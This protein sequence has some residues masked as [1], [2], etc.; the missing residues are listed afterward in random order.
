LQLEKQRHFAFLYFK[1]CQM[2]VQVLPLQR[3]S[4][5]F[6]IEDS[7]Y[8]MFVAKALAWARQF[9]NVAYLNPNQYKLPFG[10]F[11]HMLAVSPHNNSIDCKPG[12]CFETLKSL[13]ESSRDWIFGFIG[14]DVKNET[15]KL[16]SNNRDK[17]QMPEY[18]FFSP[19]HLIE[20][21]GTVVEISS[22]DEPDLV[23][24]EILNFNGSEIHIEKN[25]SS[26]IQNV[27]KEVYIENVNKIRQHIIEGDFYEMNYCMEFYAED[28]QVDPLQLYNNLNT[29]SPA[30]FSC[31]YKIGDKYLISASPERFLSKKENKLLSQPIKGTAKRGGNETEDTQ[32]KMLLLHSEKERAENLMIVDLVRN[33]LARSSRAGTV[34]VD[35]LF[36]IYS[37][38]QVHQMISTISSEIKDG[39]HFSDAIKFAFPMG[40][41]T[42]APKIRV[43]QAIEELEDSKRGVYSGAA[44]YFTPDGDFDLNVV[45]RSFIYNASSKIISF[46]AGSAITYDS[47]PEQEYQECLLKAKALIQVLHNASKNHLF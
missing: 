30:P 40:S 28:F 8:P 12:S 19:L 33:D 11:A 41:M 31:F 25:S 4:K 39:V 6:A 13:H 22:F 45:I 18:Y 47:D 23:F 36:G 32:N 9:E 46:H 10:E 16:S 37:F 2:S 3:K 1:I 29:L 43:M 26:V 5:V 7:V 44:G 14:Y 38:P 15:E 27:K 24:Q 42:G 20:Y 21:K 34:K 35:E 17:V